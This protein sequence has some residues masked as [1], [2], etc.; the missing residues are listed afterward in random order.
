MDM[1]DLVIRTDRL[2]RGDVLL[3]AD[4]E[5]KSRLTRTFSG[6]KFS[7][8]AMCVDQTTTFESDTG[9]IG[10]RFIELLADT[11][12]DGRTT[13]L[14]RA[15]GGGTTCKVYRHPEMRNVP[16]SQFTDVLAAE[17]RESYG[18]EYSQLYRLIQIARAPWMIKPL[19]WVLK[20]PVVWIFR[21]L[22]RKKRISGPFCSELVGRFFSRLGLSLFHEQRDPQRTA[23][24]DLAARSQLVLVR[25]VVLKSEQIRGLSCLWRTKTSRGCSQ[26]WNAPLGMHRRRSLPR[27]RQKKQLTRRSPESAKRLTRCRR[28]GTAKRTDSNA[29]PIL[30]A[31]RVFAVAAQSEQRR[32]L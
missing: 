16:D 29:A 18:K 20:P 15:P 26:L 11:T 6:G 31:I 14:G 12:I 5:I 17:M 27:G 3:T 21:Y 28:G 19:E 25:D 1:P 30:A 13:R 32:L 8:A 22:E 7:H 24:N 10:F 23:P 9:I 4:D 2:Q